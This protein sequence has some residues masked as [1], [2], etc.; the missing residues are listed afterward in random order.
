MRKAAWMLMFVAS[1]LALAANSTVGAKGTGAAVD[2]G[3]R[4]WAFAM[5]AAKVSDGSRATSLNGTARFRRE[6]AE[7]GHKMLNDISL[8]SVDEVHKNLNALSFA[9]PA[10]ARVGQDGVIL[11]EE[12]GRLWVMVT[13]RSPINGP[14]TTEPDLVTFRFTPTGGEPIEFTGRLASGDVSVYESSR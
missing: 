7:A 12:K 10:V 2:G 5:D 4:R 3:A 13:D 1:T 9:G 6:F 11:K 14:K 8:R